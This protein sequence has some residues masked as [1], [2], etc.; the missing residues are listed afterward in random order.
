MILP[1]DL[2]FHPKRP[3]YELDLNIIKA[4]ILCKI[5]DD[6]FKTAT[7]R[8]LLR[9]SFDLANDLVIDPK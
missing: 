2:V 9:F 1:G 5:H 8:V 7:S 3:N 6:N 4:N